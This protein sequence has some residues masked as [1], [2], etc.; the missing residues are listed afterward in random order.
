MGS[1][2]V[3]PVGAFFGEGKPKNANEFLQKFFDEAVALSHSGVDDGNVKISINCLTCD[4]PAKAF[5]LYLKGHSGY[6]SCTKCDITG[7]YYRSRARK[8]A[9]PRGVV[10]FPGTGPFNLRTDEDFRNA[11]EFDSK[12]ESILKNIPNFGFISSVPLDYMHL[13]LLGVM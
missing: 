7:I 5:V 12:T 2:K 4:T 3:Y 10:C 8:N 1:K 6:D 9:P 11:D 13:V